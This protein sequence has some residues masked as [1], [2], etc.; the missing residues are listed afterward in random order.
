MYISRI[1]FFVGAAVDSASA[2]QRSSRISR[3]VWYPEREGDVR[4]ERELG[5]SGPRRGER[6]AIDCRYVVRYERW[7]RCDW[8][9]L[10]VGA[11]RTDPVL[12]RFSFRPL[13]W[14]QALVVEILF[15]VVLEPDYIDM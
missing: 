4:P 7:R 3:G 1:S 9:G 11:T 6:V 12:L 13:A 14:R 10:R 8:S 5:F 2:R 15:T